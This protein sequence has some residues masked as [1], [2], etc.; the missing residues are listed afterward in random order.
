MSRFNVANSTQ[1]NIDAKHPGTVINKNIYGQFAEHLGRLF[2]GGLWVGPDSDIPNTRGWRN[3]VLA[4]LKDLKV[5]VLRWPGGCFSDEYRWRDGIGPPGRRPVRLN[6][7]WGRVE[8][9]N[10]V[11]THEFF[12]LVDMLGAEAYVNCNMGTGSPREM[13]D[14]LEYMTCDSRTDLAELRRRNGRDQP[15]RLHHFGIGNETWGA[16]GYMSPEYYTS[17]YKLWSTMARPPWDLPTNFVASGGH[18][19]D[20][21]DLI[22]WTEYLT[23]NIEPDFLLKF[24]AVSFHYY[25]HPRGSVWE[26]KGNAI[27]F[28]EQEWISTLHA[29]LKMD[30]FIAANKA[31]M[32]RNDPDN[33]VSF[34][35]DEWGAWYDMEEGGNCGFLYQQNSLRDAMVA[36]LNFHIFHKYAERVRMTN[37]AQMVNVLQAMILTEGNKMIVTP[38][39]HA[40]KM[41]TPFQG[42]TALPVEL[43]DTPPYQFG[44]FSIPALSASAARATDGKI[45]LALVNTNPRQAENVELKL[46]GME[47]TGASGQVLTS[48]DMDAHN[49]F[50]DPRAIAPRVCGVRADKGKLVLELP[51]KAVMVVAVTG[52]EPR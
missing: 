29:T 47:V 6:S 28:P 36:A 18:G 2:Y 35:V 4:A 3:D 12:D 15:F 40:Y 37:I 21:K 45:H 23:A 27:R 11:G 51:A 5:P 32:D 46:S 14:W 13:A 26:G 41:Y 25:T 17:R 16:G 42:A 49:T 7:L 22:R 8:E 38:T 33:H 10:A 52:L 48:A 19:G 44:E 50:D 34:H 43:G 9:S 1:I 20:E 30:Q 31:V 24:D 39:Y